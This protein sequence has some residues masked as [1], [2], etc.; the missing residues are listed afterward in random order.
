MTLELLQ[1]YQNLDPVIRQLKSWHKYKIKPVK[2]NIATVGN[3][4]LLRYFRKFNNTTK[5]YGNF[6]PR[7]EFFSSGKT[8]L[9]V[10]E[11]YKV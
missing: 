4:T 10:I 9:W 6:F 2:A 11:A 7:C 8:Q 5:N 3:K 1:N